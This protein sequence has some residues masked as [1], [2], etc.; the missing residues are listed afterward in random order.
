[1]VK[2]VGKIIVVMVVMNWMMQ[3]VLI[4]I[5]LQATFPGRLGFNRCT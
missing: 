5:N 1:M 3:E 2:H 4:L